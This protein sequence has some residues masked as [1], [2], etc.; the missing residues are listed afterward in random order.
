MFL[1]LMEQIQLTYLTFR[2]QMENTLTSQCVESI[3][4]VDIIHI[5]H[6]ITSYELLKL[7]LHYLMFVLF[8]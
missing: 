6:E 5:N 1:L 7:L 4:T 8:R 2:L 3:P